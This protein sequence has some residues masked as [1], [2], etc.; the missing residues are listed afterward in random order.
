MSITA[1]GLVAL[2]S[3]DVWAL[4]ATLATAGYLLALALI[5]LVRLLGCPLP[6]AV[7]V[8]LWG[9]APLMLIVAAY[10]PVGWP[11]WTR[12]LMLLALAML[13][14]PVPRYDR[15]LTVAVAFTLSV[16]AT[17]ALDRAVGAISGGRQPGGLVFP[18]LS[19]VH[20]RTVEFEHRVFINTYG[21]RGR[22]ADLSA[23]AGC[24]VMLLGDSFTYG[25]GVAYPH[26]WGA[27]LADALQAGGTDAQV[28][29]LGVPGG[30]T[31]DYAAIAEVAAPI[32]QPDVIVIGVLQG[33][34]MRQVTRE[35]GIYPRSLTFGEQVKPSLVADY[36]TFHY[37][38]IAERTLLRRLSANAIRRAWA[39]T[40]AAFINS[41]DDTQQARYAALPAEIR[42][43]F[44][45]G[46][47]SPHFIQLAMSAPDYWT[48]P[49]QPP[50]TLASFVEM[51]AGHFRLI[52]RAAPT[53]QTL[54]VS[55]PYGAYTQPEAHAAL[56]TL[57]FDMPESLLSN[58]H[59]DQAIAD[60]ANAAGLPFVRVTGTF[61]TA[62]ALAF[63][64]V[65]GHFNATGNA[66]MAAALVPS[67]R[68]ACLGIS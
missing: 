60:A 33:D 54:V 41:H 65:D 3:T 46:Q 6:D 52:A 16:G 57:G 15:L 45:A 8:G 22:T 28:F 34:D 2:A 58:T 4:P 56:Q 61:R 67:L 62:E 27:Q 37:P 48:W 35:A 32:L 29:N 25:W 26:T 19:S 31:A 5:A 11:L 43:W 30:G 14:R 51:M 38:F 55:V 53:A 18:R 7:G 21:F 47:V 49:T 10:S 50:Q 44:E 59:V 68:A 23:P 66:L 39:N 9:L 24:R 63:Y 36:V 40:A 64:P 13:T 42:G 20:Y 1:A 12:S 17:Y